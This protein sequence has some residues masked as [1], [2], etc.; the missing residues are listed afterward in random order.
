MR[1][2]SLLMRTRLLWPGALLLVSGAW[3]AS[4]QQAVPASQVTKIKDDLYV[5]S[6]NDSNTTVYLTNEGV[7]LVDASG[8]AH[9]DIM[10]KVK[11][12]TH[13]PIKYVISAG[14]GGDEKLRPFAVLV[15]QSNRRAHMIEQKMSGAP[16]VTFTDEMNINLGGKEVIVR[17][18][19]R[20]HTDGDSVVYFPAQKV[21]ATGDM[22]NTGG[23]FGVHVDYKSGGSI[24]EWT[25]TLD[26]ALKWDCDTV[27]PRHGPIATR[28]D[29]AKFAAN[30]EAAR[31]RVRDMVREGKTRDD[32]AKVLVGEF[33]WNPKGVGI[34]GDLPGLMDELKP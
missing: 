23:T 12:L 29:L 15:G 20:G 18:F 31:A 4:A 22:F 11:S 19:S 13:K 34:T 5:I 26:G 10:D 7:I 32:V 16:A 9:D 6:A 33:G 28:D 2:E 27:I 30:I 14:D 25:K 21:I 8:R 3:I 17:H 24:V 1:K